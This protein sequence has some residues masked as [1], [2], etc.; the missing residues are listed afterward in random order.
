MK[1]LKI[2]IILRKPHTKEQ[3]QFKPVAMKNLKSLLK[4]PLTWTFKKKKIILQS[5]T[6]TIVE[7]IEEKHSKSSFE[8][9]GKKYQLRNIGF[10][11]PKTIIEEDGKQLLALTRHFLGSK[12]SIEF[13]NGSAYSCKVRNSPLVKLSFFDKNDK[14]ILSYKLDASRKPRTILS[15]LDHSINEKELLMLLIL[16]CFSF[17]GIVQENDDTDLIVMMSGA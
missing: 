13:E 10:W 15:I 17:K 8:L 9:D 5:D 16:G 3:K 2:S 6:A 7:L 11:N 1:E 14:E 12:G 4:Q